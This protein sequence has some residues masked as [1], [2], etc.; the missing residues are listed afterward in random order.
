VVLWGVDIVL[1][2]DVSVK[3]KL[4]QNTDNEISATSLRISL[5]CPVNFTPGFLRLL[6]CPGFFFFKIPGPGK[7]WK[8]TLVLESPGN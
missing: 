6:E 8:I 5:L 4:A 2:R 3:E 7:S 1:E